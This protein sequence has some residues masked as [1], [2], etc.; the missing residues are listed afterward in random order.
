MADFPL[1]GGIR[2]G[3]AG[4]DL[5]N[6]TGTTVTAAGSAN[7]KGAYVELL[8][9]ASNEF[10]SYVVELVLGVASVAGPMLIDIAVG[11]A[12]SEE[13]IIPD[14]YIY[15]TTTAG[16]LYNVKFPIS[17]PAGERI[18]ARIQSS[19]A[20]ATLDLYIERGFSN[21]MQ[22]S[23]LSSVDAIG[24]DTATSTGTIVVRGGTIGVFGA[25]TEIIASTTDSYSALAISSARGVGSWRNGSLNYQVAVGS[26]GNEEVIIDNVLVPTSAVAFSSN[27][28]NGFDGASVAEG[29]RL[30]IRA[31]ATSINSDHD[32]DYV[33]YGVK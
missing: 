30:S 11:G 29:E 20:S 23:P 18:S 12:A 8:A 15:A 7:T 14:I 26:A 10:D 4:F 17:I 3:S 6:T 32:H 24:A 25:W 33:I 13:V 21:F 19:T 31:A 9:A 27:M 1:F 28:I 2:T 16:V 22:G 5:A